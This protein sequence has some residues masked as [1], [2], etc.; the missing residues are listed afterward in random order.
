[1]AS[2]YSTC[3]RPTGWVPYRATRSA[4]SDVDRA[5]SRQ[6]ERDVPKFGSR[7]RGRDSGDSLTAARPS[8][9]RPDAARKPG[10]QAMTALLREPTSSE[11]AVERMQASLRTQPGGAGPLPLAGNE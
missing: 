5:P 11:A 6:Y 2:W 9:P 3:P 8:P 4:R 7:L 10:N 1:M